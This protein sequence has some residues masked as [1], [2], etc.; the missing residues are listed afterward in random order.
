MT[1]VKE[2]ESQSTFSSDNPVLDP[3]NDM[4]GYAIF[5]TPRPVHIKNVSEGRDCGRYQW[6][7]GI[8]E[9]HNS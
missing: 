9:E 8:R 5:Q 7:V 4:L 2:S 6:S 3:S 1:P